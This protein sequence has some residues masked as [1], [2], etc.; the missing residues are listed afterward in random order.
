[1]EGDRCRVGVQGLRGRD[2]A[3]VVV[4]SRLVGH[5]DL[6][7]VRKEYWLSGRTGLKMTG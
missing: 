7:V 1:M 6:E 3:K 2:G 4:R 5:G